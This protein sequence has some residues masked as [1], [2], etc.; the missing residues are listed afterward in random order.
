VND[1]SHREGLLD[2]VGSEHEIGEIEVKHSDLKRRGAS[3]SPR[4]G[5]WSRPKDEACPQ[6]QRDGA[7]L[8]SNARRV[9][10]R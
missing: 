5:R 6:H 10:G 3:G 4:G 8:P 2:G 9:H 1:V 7:N